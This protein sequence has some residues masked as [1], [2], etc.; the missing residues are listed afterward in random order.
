MRIKRTGATSEQ[1]RMET[2]RDYVFH[3]YPPL[4]WSL[5]ICT[6][7][8]DWKTPRSPIAAVIL[9][10]SGDDVPARSTSA[11]FEIPFAELVP[12][13]CD[14]DVAA[15]GTPGAAAVAVVHVA[16]VNVVQTF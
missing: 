5:L 9:K 2:K 3:G 10:S 12:I 8:P 6:F 4:H 14:Q 13:A 16:G 7:Q 11:L 1:G 15:T